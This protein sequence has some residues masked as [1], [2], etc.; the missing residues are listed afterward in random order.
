ML[1]T[2]CER[3]SLSA[4]AA[5]LPTWTSMC[6]ASQPSNVAFTAAALYQ[7]NRCAESPAFHLTFLR[8]S[9]GRR[10]KWLLLCP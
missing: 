3:L 7:K 6:S 5:K 10:T 8:N 4:A 2:G 1:S 9:M